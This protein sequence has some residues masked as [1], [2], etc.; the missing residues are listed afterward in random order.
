MWCE[1]NP[2][3][4]SCC[5]LIGYVVDSS[6]ESG[7]TGDMKRVMRVITQEALDLMDKGVLE[8]SYREDSAVKFGKTW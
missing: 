2:Q 7:K 6:K 4:E 3:G 1:S 8:L 5:S